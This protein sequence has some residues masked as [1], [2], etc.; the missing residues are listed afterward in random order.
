M[1]A[2]AARTTGGQSP[3]GLASASDP[4]SV[5]RVTDQGVADHRGGPRKQ[6][7][8]AGDSGRML[9]LGGGCHRAD[10]HHLARP[11]VAARFRGAAVTEYLDSA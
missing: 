11:A 10:A 7:H 9:D 4:P 5:A 6:R 2:S 1:V 3:R 8:S